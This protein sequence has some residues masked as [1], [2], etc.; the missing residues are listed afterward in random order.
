[1]L[2]RFFVD[3]PVL[4]TVL[5]IVIVIIGLVALTQLPVA[6]Y[7]EVTPPTVQV[8]AIYPGA[9][10]ETVAKTVAT[11]IEQEV[12]GV[13]GMI[14]MASRCTNDGPTSISASASTRTWRTC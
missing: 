12:N 5:S 10:A 3:R 14:Y 9:N 1:M 4:A 13:E 6:Q 8:A 2:A 11:P 7:P